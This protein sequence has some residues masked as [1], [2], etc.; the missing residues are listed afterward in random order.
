VIVVEDNNFQG[1][2]REVLERLSRNGRAASHFWN[3]NRLTS[4]SFARDGH[5]IDSREV[6]DQTEFGD[7]PEVLEAVAGLDFTDFRHL[8][9]KGITAVVRY[10]GA[11]IPEDDVRDAIQELYR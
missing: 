7:D 3:V 8:D 5:V 9:A 2:R 10:T 4:L 1:S 11:V 6:L